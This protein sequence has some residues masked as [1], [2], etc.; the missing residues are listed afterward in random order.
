MNTAA[1]SL[2]HQEI[3]DLGLQYEPWE[4]RFFV[5]IKPHAFPVRRFFTD[6]HLKEWNKRKVE[7]INKSKSLIGDSGIMTNSIV[8]PL[9]WGKDDDNDYVASTPI[10]EY[11]VFYMDDGKW[12]AELWHGPQAMGNPMSLGITNDPNEG[13]RWC[14]G[15][16]RNLISAQLTP[17]RNR[18]SEKKEQLY[19]QLFLSCRQLLRYDGIDKDRVRNAVEEIRNTVFDMIDLK[20]NE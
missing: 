13:K 5:W 14:F 9:D 18:Q 7:N 3:I 15:H 8:R 17:H 12:L 10:G 11:H 4:T 16:W 1:H 2:T 20:E 19:D 6:N